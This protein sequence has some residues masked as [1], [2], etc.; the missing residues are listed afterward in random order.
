MW[1]E[2]GVVGSSGKDWLRLRLGGKGK[3][4]GGKGH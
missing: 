4:V 1:R 3:K 2:E